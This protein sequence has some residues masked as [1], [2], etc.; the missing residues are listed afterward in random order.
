MLKLTLEFTSP[1]EAIVA[2]GKLM[3]GKVAR[4]ANR[5][6]PVADAG[7]LKTDDAVPSVNDTAPPVAA[8]LPPASAPV[9][10]RQPRKDAGKKRGSYK[11]PEPA[12]EVDTKTLPLPLEEPNVAAAAQPD[13]ASR[14]GD[15]GASE[16]TTA[17]AATPVVE[18]DP[19]A[20]IPQVTEPPV[21]PA[22]ADVGKAVEALYNAKGMQACLDLFARYGISRWRDLPADK[23]PE[24]CV[25]AAA[26]LKA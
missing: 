4:A 5:P 23:G 15:A 1:E 10:T 25:E 16:E 20:E 22:G 8:V 12:Q 26:L 7:G 11:N 2:L 18:P 21:A 19:V 9:K 6:V 14:D 13:T 24:F 3:G 17:A